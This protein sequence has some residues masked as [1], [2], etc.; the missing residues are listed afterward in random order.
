MICINCN[1]HKLIIKREIKRMWTCQ[2]WCI[3]VTCLVFVICECPHYDKWCSNNSDNDTG[4]LFY[5][6]K[7][8]L[9]CFQHSCYLSVSF[10]ASCRWPVSICISSFSG[11][12]ASISWIFSPMHVMSCSTDKI[13]THA[14][15]MFQLVMKDHYKT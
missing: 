3:A 12:L 6:V 4:S 15:V 5:T 2:K 7:I 10:L 14:L 1:M 11:S 8:S 13:N 9:V